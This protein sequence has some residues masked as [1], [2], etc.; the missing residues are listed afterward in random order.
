[1]RQR[2]HAK[3]DL[4]AV[5]EFAPPAPDVGQRW[6]LALVGKPFVVG[7]SELTASIVDEFVYVALKKFDALPM[8]SS[9]WRRS[10]R[11]DE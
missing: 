2:P 10:Q 11:V 8:N 5:G 6:W 1:M 3:A 9:T 7:E 4:A